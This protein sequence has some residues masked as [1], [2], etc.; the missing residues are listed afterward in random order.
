VSVL[1]SRG[2]ESSVM[3]KSMTQLSKQMVSASG[4]GKKASDAFQKLGVNMADVRA[5]NTEKVLAQVSDGLK[6]IKSPADKA[7]LASQ[8]FGKAGGSKL[9]PLLYQ[10]SDAIQEQ[11]DLADKYGATLSDKTVGGVKDLAGSQREMKLAFDGVK[12]QLGS[13]L[14]PVIAEFVGVLA[15]VVRAI[16]PIISN[17]TVMK[18][19]LGVLVT[20]WVAYQAATIAAAIATTLFEAA[21]APVMIWAVLIVAAIAA[22][23][24]IGVLLYKNWDTIAQVAGQVWGA[25]QDGIDAVIGWIKANWPLLIGILTGPIGIAVALIATH[26]D[27]VVKG[28]K[29]AWDTIKS[30]LTSALNAITGAITT[31]WTGIKSAITAAVNAVDKVV[32]DVWNALVTFFTGLGDKI[33]T[34]FNAVK[35]WLSKPGEWASSAKDAAE[36]AFNLLVTFVSNLGGRVA[37][38]IDDVGTWLR[39]P[40]VW[41]DDAYDAA[42]K[43]FNSLVTFIGGLAGRVGSAMGKVASAIKAP[44]NAVIDAWNGLSFTIPSI[45]VPGWDAVKVLGKTVLPGFGGQTIGGGSWGFPNIPRLARGGVLETPTLFLGGERGREIV[46]PESLLRQIAAENTPEVHVFIGETELRGIVRTEVR[47]AGNRTAQTLLGGL[48]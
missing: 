14:I 26:W 17:A 35:T 38:A 13:A 24:A 15:Q 45:K 41:A 40:G 30:T 44:I 43:A 22:V 19:L 6:N 11:L 47:T 39:K 3:T 28:V 16:Q 37:N 34:A 2:I 18:V 33:G 46:A 36:K 27:T 21:A 20:A 7:A 9:A 29:S 32:R 23:I 31:T 5:G 12:I 10:G 4:G 8:L 48:S 42:T 1:K 25:I